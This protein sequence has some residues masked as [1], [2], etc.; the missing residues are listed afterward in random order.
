LRSA[1]G[2]LRAE[3]QILDVERV[4]VDGNTVVVEAA[5]TSS[6]LR[7]WKIGKLSGRPPSRSRT[8]DQGSEAGTADVQPV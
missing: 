2:A 7:S 3:F 6:R 8:A 1:P 4:T 5:I